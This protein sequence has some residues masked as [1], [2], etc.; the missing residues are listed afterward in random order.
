M[1]GED[2]MVALLDASRA[3]AALKQVYD[4]L[5]PE[6]IELLSCESEA[7][8][9]ALAPKWGKSWWTLGRGRAKLLELVG[10][11]LAGQRV[12]AMPAWDDEVWRG[13]LNVSGVPEE[14]P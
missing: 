14:G 4:C 11:R 12:D 9:K 6:Q 7:D 2:D 5:R 1:G 10:A 3:A 8:L 13:C